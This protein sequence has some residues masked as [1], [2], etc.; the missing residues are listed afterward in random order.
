MIVSEAFESDDTIEE[1]LNKL[2]IEYEDLIN[3]NEMSDNVNDSNSYDVNKETCIRLKI[4]K[5][6]YKVQQMRTGRDQISI[7]NENIKEILLAVRQSETDDILDERQVDFDDN[8]S[9]DMQ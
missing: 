7:N 9:T 5:L 3:D 6:Q 8:I 4:V 1:K 2:N